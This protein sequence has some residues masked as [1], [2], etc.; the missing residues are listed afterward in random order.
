MRRDS[1]RPVRCGPWGLASRGPRW[2]EYRHRARYLRA[3]HGRILR[4]WLTWSV[5]L[6]GKIGEPFRYGQTDRE[7]PRQPTTPSTSLSFMMIRSSP[8]SL[9]SLPDHLPNRILSPALTS[10]GVIVPSSARIP[11]PA[12]TT[13]PSC[14]FSLRS[15]EHTSELQS[16]MRISYAV[17]CL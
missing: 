12:E 4:P 7:R 6:Y 10:S 5:I 9:T 8:S 1:C 11:L 2:R 17:F 15:E 14:G 3:R 16:L 13:S